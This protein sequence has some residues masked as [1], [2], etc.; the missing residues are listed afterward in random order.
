MIQFAVSLQ[1]HHHTMT[2]ADALKPRLNEVA[3]TE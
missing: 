2:F 1:I 3:L